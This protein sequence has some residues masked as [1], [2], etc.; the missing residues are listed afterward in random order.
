MGSSENFCLRWNDFGSTIQDAFTD[1]QE[2]SE[3]FDITLICDD[4]QIK[5]HRVVLSACSPF[6]RKVF[7]KNPHQH[8]LLYL[9]TMKISDISALLNFM[10]KGETNVNQD[11]INDFLKVAEALQIK[12]L[13]DKKEGASGTSFGGSNSTPGDPD[14][15]PKT[16][17]LD[18]GPLSVKRPRPSNSSV[19]LPNTSS[20][21]R[22]VIASAPTSMHPEDDDIEEVT[23]VK[24]EPKDHSVGPP[25]I[26]E[27]G[28]GSGGGTGSGNENPDD[29]GEDSYAGDDNY[30]DYGAYGS[31]SGD[32]SYGEGG[33][34]MD[35][36]AACPS[37]GS[38]GNKGNVHAV[39]ALDTAIARL[40][41][42]DPASGKYSCRKCGRA[43]GQKAAAK[44]HVEAK[45]VQ[46]DGF[47]CSF[48]QKTFKTRNS[49]NV[50]ISTKHTN[51]SYIPGT[52]PVTG[53]SYQ[54]T[55]S[56]QYSSYFYEN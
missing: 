18:G 1:L 42:K 48:C 30:D 8:P 24:S 52:R 21:P 56:P 15:K 4:G 16:E 29:M 20:T 38:D 51:P 50:H 13:S 25:G 43:F 39:L 33:E 11:A 53:S 3:Y 2:D 27:S 23:P 12:G 44:N 28:E 10:Y 32:M 22:P 17:R 6:F 9:H 40:I 55:S 41:N 26:S 45:H 5:A 31:E 46:T 37:G 34:T 14:V 19:K 47:D 7:K 35:P 54:A 36:N 49:L